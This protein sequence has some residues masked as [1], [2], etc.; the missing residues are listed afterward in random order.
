MSFISSSMAWNSILMAAFRS[1]SLGSVRFGGLGNL[2]WF[3]SISPVSVFLGLLIFLFIICLTWGTVPSGFS[4]L[5]PPVVW[6]WVP[7]RDVV[8]RMLGDIAKFWTFPPP[9]SRLINCQPLQARQCRFHHWPV[10]GVLDSLERLLSTRSRRR[11]PALTLG[12]SGS[13]RFPWK[14]TFRPLQSEEKLFK[15]LPSLIDTCWS[16]YFSNCTHQS[17]WQASHHGLVLSN[18]IS[19]VSG[20]SY[21]TIFHLFLNPTN[22]WVT[23]FCMYLSPFDYLSPHTI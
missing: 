21:H 18:L 11:P 7:S 12:C 4:P 23:L 6:G 10:P 13:S 3:P 15:K 14:T 9:Q 22:R 19:V 2:F 5:L 16:S 8:L 17:L 1:S 20:Y